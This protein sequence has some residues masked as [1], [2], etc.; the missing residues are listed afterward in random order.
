MSL[1][2]DLFNLQKV[3]YN[4]VKVRQRFQRIQESL[5]DNEEL[6]AIRRNVSEV[7]SKL[8][9]SRSQQRKH[10]LD[11]QNLATRI[12]ETDSQLMGGAVT[13]HKELESL[14]A[15]LESLKRQHSTAEEQA[16]AALEQSETLSS[17]LAQ[18]KTDL[19]SIETAWNE[20]V[21]ELK[22]DG[23]KLQHHFHVLKKKRAKIVDSL[24][25]SALELYEQLRKRKAGVA[26]APLRDDTC[27]ACNMQVPSGIASAARIADKDPV[28]CSNCGRILFSE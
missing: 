13:N 15:S 19:N 8:E 7:E 28:Y 25:G 11:A 17:Q 14:Q 1:L 18:L 12:E 23:K 10:E 4:A 20:K 16:V 5:S 27:G 24:D 6:E 3:D 2:S 26:I 22:G 9:E 21:S